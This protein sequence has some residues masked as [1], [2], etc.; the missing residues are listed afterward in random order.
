[1]LLLRRAAAPY[2]R[3][4]D[5]P[6]GFADVGEAP[7]VTLRREFLEETGIE[8]SV[9]APLG[10]WPDVYEDPTCVEPV[11]HTLNLVYRVEAEL[12]LGHIPRDSPE[13]QVKWWEITRL[14]S[15][16]AFPDSTGRALA[17]AL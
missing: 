2:R 7:D 17:A 14:P 11:R 16:I 5:L 4:W 1:V 10:G 8:V 15:D 9:G 12:P 6:G 3:F 13:G